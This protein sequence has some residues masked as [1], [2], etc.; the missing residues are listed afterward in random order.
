M[1]NERISDDL[2]RELENYFRLT[3]YW[4]IYKTSFAKNRAILKRVEKALRGAHG[5]VT[6]Q[7]VKHVLDDIRR[8]TGARFSPQTLLAMVDKLVL[9]VRGVLVGGEYWEN[10]GNLIEAAKLCLPR[11]VELVVRWWHIGEYQE[12]VRVCEIVDVEVACK[13]NARRWMYR[14]SVLL[15]WVL[16]DAL[17]YREMRLRLGDVRDA[18]RILRGGE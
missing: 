16:Q 11:H 18:D 2:W 15:S 6:M 7:E 1:S 8:E 9:G 14:D 3:D 17:R 10:L 4:P 12:A 5:D 13:R